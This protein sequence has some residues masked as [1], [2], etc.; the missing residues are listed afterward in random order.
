MCVCVCWCIL[1]EYMSMCIQ[2]YIFVCARICVYVVVTTK[3]AT[4]QMLCVFSCVR[5]CLLLYVRVC[6]CVY[7]CVCVCVCCIACVMPAREMCNNEWV[8]YPQRNVRDDHHE[9]CVGDVLII[10]MRVWS[11]QEFGMS[12]VTNI[13]QWSFQ[14]VCEAC[15]KLCAHA[16]RSWSAY[17]C[18][19]V[20]LFVYVCIFEF[21]KFTWLLEFVICR[22]LVEFMMVYSRIIACVLCVLKWVAVCCGV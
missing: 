14:C 21:V 13:D 22:R 2:V 8:K 16:R 4:L 18:A 12:A 6:V 7:V 17:V 15:R 10:P 3:H 1:I 9:H 5:V 11:L 20:C 19:R